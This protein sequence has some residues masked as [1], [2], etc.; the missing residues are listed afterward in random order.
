MDFSFDIKIKEQFPEIDVIKD[1]NGIDDI[2]LG[3]YEG[4]QQIFTLDKIFDKKNEL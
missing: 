1:D 4:K 3:I 2:I